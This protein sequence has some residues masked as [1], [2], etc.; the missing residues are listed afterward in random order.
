MQ[1]CNPARNNRLRLIETG[2]EPGTEQDNV[3]SP[4]AEVPPTRTKDR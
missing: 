2:E 1:E 3:P 4:T